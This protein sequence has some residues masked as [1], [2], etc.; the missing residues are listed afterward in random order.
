MAQQPSNSERKAIEID[1]RENSHAQ[2]GFTSDLFDGWDVEEIADYFSNRDEM[3]IG[4]DL[5]LTLETQRE[6][7]M[8]KNEAIASQVDEQKSTTQRSEDHENNIDELAE[9]E[10]RDLENSSIENEQS[11]YKKLFRRLY[12]N[13]KFNNITEHYNGNSSESEGDY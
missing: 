8:I 5:P 11:T 10:F 9:R 3:L 7:D 4:S 12:L 13:K 2:T 6:I 1:E